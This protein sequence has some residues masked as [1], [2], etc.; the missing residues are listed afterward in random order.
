MCK[1][2]QFKTIILKRTWLYLVGQTLSYGVDAAICEIVWRRLANG[3]L[4][5]ENQA[6]KELEMSRIYYD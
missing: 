2:N 6:Y 4:K 3:H 1:F 5:N